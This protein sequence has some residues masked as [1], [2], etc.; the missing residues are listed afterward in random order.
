MCLLLM[1]SFYKVLTPE[2][3]EQAAQNEYNFNIPGECTQV[4]MRWIIGGSQ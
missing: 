4:E 2:Q 3:H 1:D